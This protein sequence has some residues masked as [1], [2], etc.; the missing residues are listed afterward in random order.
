MAAPWKPY[1]LYLPSKKKGAGNGRGFELVHHVTHAASALR[2]F[3]DGRIRA[4]DVAGIS[5]LG[6]HRPVCWL[7]P[8]HW[9]NGS[10]YGCAQFS[11]NFDDLTRDRKIYWVIGADDLE[12]KQCVLLVTNR[13]V[14]QLPVK[15]YRPAKSKGPL[16][17]H[18]GAWMWRSD[19]SLKIIVDRDLTI[20]DVEI[21]GFVKH[22]PD[23]CI[24]HEDG[25]CHENDDD[26]GRACARVLAGLISRRIQLPA[27]F[28]IDNGRPA[29]WLQ[30]GKFY[31][32]KTL[33]G[34]EDGL[35][36]QVGRK[37]QIDS[38]VA[39][40]LASL[41]AGQTQTAAAASALI[42]SD[43]K[44]AKSIGRL[45]KRWSHGT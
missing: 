1:R 44:L 8:N 26:A 35:S 23:M 36:G 34:H 6:Q 45:V 14:S 15:R 12:T 22:H 7:A 2:I 18:K 5:A 4:S 28:L 40:S 9:V 11:F 25:D 39:A 19:V 41:A 43:T 16:R 32:E 31:I 37:R 27:R 21:F 17:R 42:R 20:E 33:G 10:H 13:D 30:T 38:I 3:S 24:L 29:G